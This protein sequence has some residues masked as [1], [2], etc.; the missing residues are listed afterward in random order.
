MP[1][2]A[3]SFSQRNPQPDQRPAAGDRGYDYRWQRLSKSYRQA[4]PLCHVPTCN[5]PTAVVD[6]IIPIILAPDR[7]L[8]WENLRSCCSHHHNLITANFRTTGRNELPAGAE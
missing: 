2:K 4:Y 5:Q 6:H 8:D 1:L 7:R 3:L